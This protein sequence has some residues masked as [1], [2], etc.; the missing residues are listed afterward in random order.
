MG[1]IKF[2][3]QDWKANAGNTKGRF[4]L[5]L[6][7]IGNYSKKRKALK[8]L[9]I[10]HLILYKFFVEW[11][12]GIEL[13]CSTTI[14]KDLKLFHGQALVIHKNTIVGSNCTIRHSTTIGNKGGSDKRCP[15][16]GTNVNI[17]A[18]V[19]IIGNITVGDNAVIG[20]GSVVVKDVPPNATVVGNPARVIKID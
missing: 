1:F 18:H 15:V 13:P 6:Y 16:I 20:S 10:P 4:I 8:I 17:G 9:F 3:F 19:C 14:G 5:V 2:V 7:R 11:I 12:L